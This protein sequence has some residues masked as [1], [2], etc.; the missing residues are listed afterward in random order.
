MTRLVLCVVCRSIVADG[1]GARCAEC[2]RL[3][4]RQYDASR[5]AHHQVYASPE[6]RKLSAEVRATA[7]RCT[8][9]LKPTRRLIADHVIPVEQ[10]PDLALDRSNVV[11]ACF[12][13]NTRRGRNARLPDLAP[14]GVAA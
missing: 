1:R 4:T 14:V 8:W 2:R 10:R 5:P 13:C 7:T 9:C 3:W 11:P 12:S 6:W